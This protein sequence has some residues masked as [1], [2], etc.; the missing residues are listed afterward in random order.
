MKVL[1]VDDDYLALESLC[2]ILKWDKFEGELI[3]CATD[4]TEAISQILQNR[5]DV[6]VSDIK[7]PRTDGIALARYIY[8]NHRGIR[9]ILL[10]G[11]SEF[12]YAQKALKYQVF[13]YILKPITRA[14]ITAL[15]KCLTDISLDLNTKNAVRSLSGDDSMKERLLSILRKGDTATLEEFLT[16]GKVSATLLRDMDGSLG[17]T[18]LGYLFLYQEELEK[19]KSSLA[20]L[21]KSSLKEYWELGS[22]RERTDY[23]LSRCYE[24]MACAEARKGEYDK[25]IVAYCI[26]TIQERF[27][28]PLFNISQLA[29][30]ANLSP[31]YLST[32]FKQTVG[33]N[34]SR[35]LSQQRL[36][37]AQKLLRDISI[38]IRDV[39]TKSGYEDPHYFARSFKKQTG[40]TP[41]EYRN[42]YSSGS[43]NPEASEGGEKS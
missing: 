11:H 7:M 40:M 21:K 42:L 16:S 18:L 39:C 41:S 23:L 30:L 24:V 3:G 10:S 19:D 9:M 8:E 1:L 4:G 2:H 15:E 34:I 33:Q 13:D 22:P 31:P 37:H 28:D 12:D 38:P 27:S 35:Y 17:A 25:P 14:K 6:V 26:Q 5:P 29:D 32:V 20:D 36:L 43:L